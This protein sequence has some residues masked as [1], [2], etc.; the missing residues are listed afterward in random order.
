[1]PT[2]T[3]NSNAPTLVAIAIAAR[4]AGDREL[5]RYA[6]GQLQARHG[7]KLTFAGQKTSHQREVNHR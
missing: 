2:T 3:E 1:M 5:E 7:V 6:K 4:R